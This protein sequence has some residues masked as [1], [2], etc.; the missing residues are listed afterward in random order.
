MSYK[1]FQQAA[2]VSEVQA[3]LNRGARPVITWEPWVWGGGLQQPDY[4]LAR[5]AAGY[6][7]SYIRSW[8]TALA[9]YGNSVTLRFAHEMNGDW[10]PWCPGVNGSTAADFIAAWRR[11]YGIFTANGAR[12]LWLW[13]VN[14]P[15]PG[16]VPLASVYPGSDVVDQLGLDTY[17]FGTSQ[18]WSTWKSPAQTFA[19]GFDALRALGTGRRIIISE[20][21]SSELGGSKAN[22]IRD[23]IPYLDAQP[24][25][26]AFIWFHFLK[27]TD[28]R[29]NSSKTAAA[30]FKKALAARTFA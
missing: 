23:A 5:I 3:C 13:S 1:D 27:E 25:V 29:I 20:T 15:Y 30:A 11:I 24:D 4:S 6:F 2:P 19:P 9:P 14:D 22:W 7:D 16:S 17:N 8:A 12:P 21:A 18:S 28:W 26:D 10:Y